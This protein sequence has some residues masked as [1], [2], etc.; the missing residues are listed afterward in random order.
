[1]MPASTNRHAKSDFTSP[2]RD[3]NKHDV[4]NP[5]TAYDQG[6]QCNDK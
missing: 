6:N 4:H 3:G 2:L 5:D 1:M